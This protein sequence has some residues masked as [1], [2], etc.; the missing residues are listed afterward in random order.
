MV[1]LGKSYCSVKQQG[2]GAWALTKPHFNMTK[3][4]IIGLIILPWVIVPLPGITDAFRI[5]QAVFLNL[6]FMGMICH[7]FYRGLKFNYFNKYLSL[8]AAWTFITI[9]FN[10]Y[11]PLTMSFNNRQ[12]INIL[13]ITP[14]I[15]FILGLW[16]TFIALSYFEREDF[17]KIAKGIC[18]SAVLITL[19]GIMQIIGFD[20]FGKIATY[21]HGNHFSACLDNPN[22]VG[23]Y[24][25]LSL[26]MFFSMKEKK[27]FWGGFLV[28]AGIILA[29]A[30]LAIMCAFVGLCFYA[31]LT[32]RKNIKI[33]SA[34]VVMV[35]LFSVFCFSNKKF[36]K[37]ESG[38]SYR[39][40]NWKK[41]V[42]F[43]KVNPLFGQGLG[44]FRA[45][46]V[47]DS[48]MTKVSTP[49]NDWL[50][51]IVEVGVL[52]T[53]LLGLIILNSFR[54]F[55][56]KEINPLAFSYLISFLMFLMLMCGSFPVQIAPTMLLGLIAFW[57]VEKA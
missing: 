20:P 30:T 3:F 52:G 44:R 57:G 40:E 17:E 12:A 25:C 55:N 56:Y 28:L 34:I 42:E 11:M 22:I 53:F 21:N 29:K 48:T 14:S 27:Y 49:H 41:T 5:P 36:L 24:L 1:G 43:I 9:F 45:Y 15:H 13:T 33:K 16:A 47:M 39:L 6:I 10:W 23:N 2:F 18:F 31:L 8:F 38:F 35:I 26:P 4:L 19:F 50:D 32:C 54:N 51:R 37:I 46:D 7:S